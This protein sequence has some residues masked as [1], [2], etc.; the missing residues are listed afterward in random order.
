LQLTAEDKQKFHE[1]LMQLTGPINEAYQIAGELAKKL[2]RG[3]SSTNK[4]CIS[5]YDNGLSVNG[6]MM[7]KKLLRV[8]GV[9]VQN[10]CTSCCVPA[11][12]L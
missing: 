11:A 1:L 9:Q 4:V 8:Y 5:H 3:E 6:T 12:G 2:K 7:V 10:C